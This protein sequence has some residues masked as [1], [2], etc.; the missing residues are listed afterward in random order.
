M[1]FRFVGF[2]ERLQTSVRVKPFD[3]LPAADLFMAQG[4]RS[5]DASYIPYAR[6]PKPETLDQDGLLGIQ[7]AKMNPMKGL[8]RDYRV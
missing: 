2:T 6:N 3:D 4:F 5:P 8:L 1:G 7:I